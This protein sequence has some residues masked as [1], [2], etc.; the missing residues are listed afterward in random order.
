[1]PTAQ[2]RQGRR[3]DLTEG[4]SPRLRGLEV[5]DPNTHVSARRVHV[6]NVIRAIAVPVL[7]VQVP[8]VEGYGLPYD[9][10]GAPVI[11]AS[12]YDHILGF[13]ED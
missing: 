8:A 5:V 3:V 9:R 12:R 7:Q 4:I 10:H 2:D 6:D 11:L 13:G 1:M